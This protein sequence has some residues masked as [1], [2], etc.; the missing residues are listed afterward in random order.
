MSR[1]VN[2]LILKNLRMYRHS[3]NLQTTKILSGCFQYIVAFNAGSVCKKLQED[4]NFLPFCR[5]KIP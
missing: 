5:E 4:R 2:V 3:E 1:G